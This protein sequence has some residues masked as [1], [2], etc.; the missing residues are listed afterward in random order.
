MKYIIDYYTSRNTSFSK[1]T[2]VDDLAKIRKEVILNSKFATRFPLV[3]RDTHD[4]NW[5]EKYETG[6]KPEWSAQ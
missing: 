2:Y 3:I 1:D 6:E 4:P 5:F